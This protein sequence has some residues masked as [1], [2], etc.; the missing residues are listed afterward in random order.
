MGRGNI[1]IYLG[2]TANGFAKHIVGDIII[3]GRDFAN[4]NI[5]PLTPKGMP[6]TRH[7]GNGFTWGQFQRTMPPLSAAKLP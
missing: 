7:Q 1:L 2:E 3:D 5:P 4:Q 6:I